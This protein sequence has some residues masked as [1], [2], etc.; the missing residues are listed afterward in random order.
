MRR[1]SRLIWNETS[2]NVLACLKR[3]E[4]S[5]IRRSNEDQLLVPDADN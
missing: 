1:E 4:M 2:K 3:D 5:K